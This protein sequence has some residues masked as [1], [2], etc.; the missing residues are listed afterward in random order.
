MNT[1]IK[2]NYIY[3]RF[4]LPVGMMISQSFNV[5]MVGIGFNNIHIKTWLQNVIILSTNYFTT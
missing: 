3:K 5:K 1:F 4:I 2:N